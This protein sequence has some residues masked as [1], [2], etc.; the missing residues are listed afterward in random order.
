V[1]AEPRRATQWDWHCQPLHVAL[2]GSFPSWHWLRAVVKKTQCTAFPQGWRKKMECI[3]NILTF[4]CW[5]HD[6]GTS[7]GLL[8]LR[9]QV[10]TRRLWM[11]YGSWKQRSAQHGD[12][13]PQRT[14][15]SANILQQCVGII[16]DCHNHKSHTC[17]TA[18]ELGKIYF[19]RMV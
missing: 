19:C 12:T 15:S 5:G 18:D 4:L 2:D 1:N 7:F 6:W 16:G 10:K 13:T 8:W 17:S 14:C 3:F 9:A 11:L